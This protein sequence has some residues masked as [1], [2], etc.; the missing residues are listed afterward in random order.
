[1]SKTKEIFTSESARHSILHDENSILLGFAVSPVTDISEAEGR[2]VVLDGTLPVVIH[3][4]R[5]AK[6]HPESDDGHR[7]AVRRSIT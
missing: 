7:I 1:M 6:D 4:L 5:L 2:H 3:S